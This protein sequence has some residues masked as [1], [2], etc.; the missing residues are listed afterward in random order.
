M[1]NRIRNAKS[2]M[3]A[4]TYP[5]GTGGRNEKGFS[6]IE[7]IFAMSFLTAIVFGVISLQTSNVAMANRQKNQIQANF[8]ANQ[9]VQI[10][11]SL[12]YSPAF[13]ACTP[14][15]CKKKLDFIQSSGEYKLMDYAVSPEQIKDTV[16][17][18]Y[19]DIDS[20]GLS[21]AYKAT[22]YIEWDDSTGSHR[23]EVDGKTENAHVEAKIIISQ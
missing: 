7:L 11:K 10:L 18:R 15:T 12:G 22:V 8:Y 6:L 19:I 2:E 4:R 23:R 9:G 20:K 14:A 16:F 13:S 5:F 17:E 21:N 1:K 3:P